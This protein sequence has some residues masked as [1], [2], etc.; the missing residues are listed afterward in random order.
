MLTAE[1]D[2][3]RPDGVRYAER[4][5]AAGVEVVHDD[6]PGAGHYFLTADPDRAQVTMAMV[7]DRLRTTLAA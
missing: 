4:L 7:A 5:R 2:T 3:L 6:T 1:R